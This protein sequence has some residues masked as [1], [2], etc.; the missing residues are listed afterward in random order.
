MI[1]YYKKVPRLA[2]GPRHLFAVPHWKVLLRR[3]LYEIGIGNS[4][5][6]EV[7]SQRV[8]KVHVLHMFSRNVSTTACSYVLLICMVKGRVG[9]ILSR[10]NRTLVSVAPSKLPGCQ[11]L[12]S[13]TG[14]ISGDVQNHGITG[15]SHWQL[16]CQFTAR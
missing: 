11:S 2:N 7:T 10:G 15:A 4:E 6:L 3:I 1:Y 16:H 12:H 14:I 5:R 9:R 13:M 8:T